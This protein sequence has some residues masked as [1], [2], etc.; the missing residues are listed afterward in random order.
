MIPPALTIYDR[1]D[2]TLL[3]A[4]GRHYRNAGQAIAAWEDGRD[5]QLLGGSYC[6]NRDRD[7]LISHGYVRLVFFDSGHQ[8]L[9]SIPL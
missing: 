9:G 7:F 6:S 2:L 4:Y 5:F 8:E 1:G 3:P